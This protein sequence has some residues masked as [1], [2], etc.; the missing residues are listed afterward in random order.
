MYRIKVT[1]LF[2]AAEFAFGARDRF[3]APS[4]PSF[5]IALAEPPA[6]LVVR[7]MAAPVST[8]GGRSTFFRFG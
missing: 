7:S 5:E 6:A 2:R 3:F 8:G 4:A 1:N